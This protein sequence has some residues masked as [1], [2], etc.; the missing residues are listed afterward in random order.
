MIDILGVRHRW[1]LVVLLFLGLFGLVLVVTGDEQGPKLERVIT[2]EGIE[3]DVPADW[4][5]VGERPFEFRPP[6]EMAR[7]TD[8]WLVAMACGQEGCVR[9]T[10]AEWAELGDEL[11]T[12]VGARADEGELLFDL[13]EKSDHNSRVLTA[14][15]EAGETQVF[16]AVF[17]DG[18]DHYVECGL[19]VFDDVD[20]LVD[21][22]V[23]ACKAA[24]PPRR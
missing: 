24:E 18:A 3:V 2:E 17:H 4:E 14:R 8:R 5:P 6:A 12:F 15:T 10:V 21:A 16:V 9:R 23:D 22:I 19:S 13:E 1:A 11:P 20:G 7:T